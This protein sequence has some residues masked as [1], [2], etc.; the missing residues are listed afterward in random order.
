MTETLSYKNLRA[1]LYPEKVKTV[2]LVSGAGVLVA[3]TVL[4]RISASGKFKTVNS[5]N[6]DGSQAPYAILL[7]DI[8]AS[9]AD[10]RANVAFTGDFS[11]SVLVFG[12]SDTIAT[13]EVA[14]RNIGLF[15][16]E[17][18]SVNGTYTA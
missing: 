3:G 13:H 16:E 1:G 15:V 9:A 18:V 6:S 12:G 10:K 17:T 5:A 7:E 2:I 14:L 4:G 8:D 11:R